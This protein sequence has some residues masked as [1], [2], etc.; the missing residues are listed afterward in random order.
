VL[1]PA[2]AGPLGLVTEVAQLKA[3]ENT[4]MYR[5][6]TDIS[7]S[8][9]RQNVLA[10]SRSAKYH[11]PERSLYLSPKDGSHE[12]G[13][14]SYQGFSEHTLFKRTFGLYDPT[15]SSS[16]G[17]LS[18]GIGGRGSRWRR[19]CSRGMLHSP[20]A[21]LIADQVQFK[22][23]FVPLE[24]DLLSLETDDVARD[25]YLVRCPFML[26]RPSSYM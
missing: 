4:I 6:I 22:L 25:L 13:S 3:S 21:G 10:G 15:C 7:A 19:H 5:S 26:I 17:A 12:D 11:D 8:S 18:K 23:E 1:E 9:G 16:H 14:G 20:L 24:D 2:L